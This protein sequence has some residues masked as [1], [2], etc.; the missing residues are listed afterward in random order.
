V[1]V[2]TEGF[3]TPHPVLLLFQ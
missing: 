3:P 1:K 2:A